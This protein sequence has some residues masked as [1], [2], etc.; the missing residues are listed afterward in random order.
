[1]QLTKHA[2]SCVTL[3]KDEARIVID[4]GMF[5]G[6]A[7]QAVAE[8]DAVLITHEHPDHFDE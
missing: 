4:P 7:A 5:T 3:A 6:E 1:M 8:A 2:H